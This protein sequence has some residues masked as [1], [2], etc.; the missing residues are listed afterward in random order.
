MSRPSSN[1][2]VLIAICIG[3]LFIATRS[4]A[5]ANDT[6]C[7]ES[8][9][10]SPA[11]SSEIIHEAT[12][13]N[14]LL[15]LDGEFLPR[16]YRICATSAGTSVN[17]RAVNSPLPPLDEEDE[18]PDRESSRRRPGWRWGR[19]PLRGREAGWAS[20]RTA[21]TLE[22]MLA[23][24]AIVVGFANQELTIIQQ[25]SKQ[26]D[27]LQM[28]LAPDPSSKAFQTLIADRATESARARWK[29]W[30]LGFTSSDEFR[31]L[32]EQKIAFVDDIE[33]RNSR[34]S[35]AMLRAQAMAYPLTVFGMVLGVLALGHLLRTAPKP[36]SEPNSMR[37][38]VIR[39]TWVTLGLI[40]VMSACDLGWTILASSAG[41]MREL[42]P[43]GSRLIEHPHSL[44]A[45][46]AALTMIGC[47]IL[48]ALRCDSRAQLVSWWL[49]LVSA[50]LTFRWVMFHSL[51]LG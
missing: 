43:L 44:I 21:E 37:P 14:G 24:D 50:V 25:L 42:N 49:C 35:Q 41:Q 5:F 34:A 13:D 51:F 48:G 26:C 39:A 27:F 4:G 40:A 17:G 10:P 23:N 47:G 6:V 36:G 18:H 33:A 31:S 29:E 30:I 38:D 2:L 15:F 8:A 28:L 20:R 46:K 45:F 19:M 12:I 9:G 16:P 7:P 1:S 11:V 3:T 32:A 22:Q